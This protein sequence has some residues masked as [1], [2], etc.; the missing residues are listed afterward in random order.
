MELLIDTNIAIYF[1]GGE[2]PLVNL[3]H[4]EIIHL[5]FIT[6]LE[7]LAYENITEE[8]LSKIEAFIDDCVVVDINH[9]IKKHTIDIR[10]QSGIRLPDAII[11]ATAR[12]EFMPLLSADKEFR[13][14]KS[15]QLFSYQF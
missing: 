6:Q 12:S 4:N 5:S 11:A 2:K 10:K 15:L 14:V 9:S 8:E 3:L 7:L 1:L 13:K